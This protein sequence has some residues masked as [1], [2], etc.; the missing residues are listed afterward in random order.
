[1][2]SGGDFVCCQKPFHFNKLGTEKTLRKD[3]G[4]AD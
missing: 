3:G 1:V 2:C 4:R